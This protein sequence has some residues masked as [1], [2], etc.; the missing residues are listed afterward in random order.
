MEEKTI[1]RTERRDLARQR[2]SLSNRLAQIPVLLA[3]A[4]REPTEESRVAALAAVYRQRGDI[5]A[6]IERIDAQLAQ[7]VEVES[8]PHFSIV[9]RCG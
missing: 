4:E 9:T 2:D 3:G 5:I 8:L 1:S 7:P 6:A